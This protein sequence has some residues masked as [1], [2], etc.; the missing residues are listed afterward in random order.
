MFESVVNL[1]EG[2]NSEL[3]QQLVDRLDNVAD[4]HSDSIH[5]R[6]VVTILSTSAEQV[7]AQTQSLARSVAELLDISQCTGIHPKIGSL[8]VVPFVALDKSQFM[9]SMELRDTFAEWIAS[10]LQIP[11]FVFGPERSLPEIRREAYKTLFPQFGPTTP[12]YKL[13]SCCVGA[14]PVMVAYNV[15]LDSAHPEEVKKIPTLLRG[16]NARV[17][18][19]QYEERFQASANLINPMIY[20]PDHF[21]DDVTR[22]TAAVHVDVLGAELVGLVPGEVLSQIDPARWE[23][24][25]LTM[26]KTI[27]ARLVALEG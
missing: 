1:S 19:F 26:G 4:V 5:D 15:W 6:T 24:L 7:L 20:R 8:D 10:E 23:E 17:L 9:Q 25:D 2:K 11:A 12:N 3:V 13:G 18:A 27:E 22:L 21:Y 16:P 14:R